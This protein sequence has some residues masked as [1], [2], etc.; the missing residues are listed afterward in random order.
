MSKPVLWILF[1]IACA[2]GLLSQSKDLKPK[3][4]DQQ[5]LELRS[6][7]VQ[8]YQAKEVLEST[9]Q[10]RAFMQT[11]SNMNEVSLRIQREIGCVPPK[12]Q[13]TQELE[14]VAVPAQNPPPEKK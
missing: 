9:P 2:I 12:W 14:C 5:K 4:T 3:L 8:L 10:F 1:L 6:A 7:Q 11:Q 13:F